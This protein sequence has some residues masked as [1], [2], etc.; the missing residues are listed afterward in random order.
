MKHQL[1]SENPYK[2]NKCGSHEFEIEVEGTCLTKVRIE[3]PKDLNVIM[4][5]FECTDLINYNNLDGDMEWEVVG[6]WCCAI[7]GG[8]DL[9]DIDDAIKE[10]D[11][12]MRKYE[13]D[14][15]VGVVFTI[16]AGQ[17]DIFTGDV[18]GETIKRRFEFGDVL[19]ATG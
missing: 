6:S 12:A 1:S 11:D 8:H 2:C 3:V 18:V 19:R 16:H 17:I 13:E 5:T 15:A 7:C 4:S 9:I 14:E 10:E